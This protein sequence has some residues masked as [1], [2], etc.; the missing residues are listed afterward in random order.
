[1]LSKNPILHTLLIKYCK[2]QP[3]NR[4]LSNYFVIPPP[5]STKNAL[6]YEIKSQKSGIRGG[7]KKERILAQTTDQAFPA[8]LRYTGYPKLNEESFNFLLV[9]DM[10]A[11]QIMK[12]LKII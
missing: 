6:K 4:N 7:K 11:I 8:I 1:M 9:G 2:H 12:V 3:T 5:P 10:L